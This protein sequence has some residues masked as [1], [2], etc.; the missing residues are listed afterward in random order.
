MASED[1]RVGYVPEHFSTPLHFAKRHF[2]AP[3]EL[4]PFPSGTGAMISALQDHSIDVAVGLTEGWVAGLALAA[5]A[6]ETFAY[7][8]VGTYVESPL[9]WAVS[10]GAGREDLA[11]E[12]DPGEWVKGLKG[13]K[14]GVSRVGSGSYVMG[15]MMADKLGFL[16]PEGENEPFEVV[17]LE[18]FEKLRG[19]VVDGKADF[20]LCE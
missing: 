1:L 8:L 6:N 11:T 18:T 13:K 7:G 15:Y 14:M 2:S 3:I 5:A 19:G 20:F 9:R 12:Q 10:T 4:L 17:P 16:D